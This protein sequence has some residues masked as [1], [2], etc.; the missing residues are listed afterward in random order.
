MH[1]R[2]ALQR[3]GGKFHFFGWPQLSIAS[4]AAGRP[5]R[6]ESPE[7]ATLYHRHGHFK[8][9]HPEAIPLGVTMASV[10]PPL[11]FGVGSRAIVTEAE[12]VTWSTKRAKN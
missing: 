5:R 2:N 7:C 4:E 10:S 6:V 11:Y 8:F 12:L 3:I 1:S 9:Q